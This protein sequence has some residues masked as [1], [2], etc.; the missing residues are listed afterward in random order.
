MEYW[1]E[2]DGLAFLETVALTVALLGTAGS[3]TQTIVTL[4]P[5]VNTAGSRADD[6]GQQPKDVFCVAAHIQVSTLGP[7]ST[8][9]YPHVPAAQCTSACMGSSTACLCNVPATWSFLTSISTPL[10]TDEDHLCWACNQDSRACIH[11]LTFLQHDV[12]CHHV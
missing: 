4:S 8:V 10:K 11:L 7:S 9:E 6:T 1:E 3:I 12:L 2:Q 5:S